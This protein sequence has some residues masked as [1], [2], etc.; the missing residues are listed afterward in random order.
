MTIQCFF[1][2]TDQDHIYVYADGRRQLTKSNKYNIS[3]LI[4]LQQNITFHF[5]HFTFRWLFCSD[6][7]TQTTLNLNNR[8]I[9]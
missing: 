9:V 2:G 1:P 6:R 8:M 4:D 5:S 7:I 3:H